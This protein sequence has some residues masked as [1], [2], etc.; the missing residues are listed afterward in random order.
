MITKAERRECCCLETKCQKKQDPVPQDAP[1]S[2][3]GHAWDFMVCSEFPIINQLPG[4][5]AQG[6]QEPAVSGGMG[7]PTWVHWL[8]STDSCGEGRQE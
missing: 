4:Q 7:G 6:A 8:S 1:S 5:G 2:K 3:S